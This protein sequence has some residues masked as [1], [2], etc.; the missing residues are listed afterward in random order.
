MHTKQCE[1]TASACTCDEKYDAGAVSCGLLTLS[2][3]EWGGSALTY[4]GATITTSEDW[5][6]DK[7]SF[8]TT[9]ALD[10]RE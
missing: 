6:P 8:V 9:N 4:S 7:V 2:N 10:P 3:V 1:P 5:N